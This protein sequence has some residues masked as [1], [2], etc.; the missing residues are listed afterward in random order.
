MAEATAKVSVIREIL[1]CSFWNTKQQ[2]YASGFCLIV[3]SQHSVTE[4]LGT[5]VTD[6]KVDGWESQ[7]D[8]ES[9]VFNVN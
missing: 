8:N 5:M 9:P 7:K 2:C 3:Y 1:K 6:M 4:L